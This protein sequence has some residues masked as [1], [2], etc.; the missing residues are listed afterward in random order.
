MTA[1]SKNH[2]TQ[3]S[4][5]ALPIKRYAAACG[6]EAV[7][8]QAEVILD[9][10]PDPELPPPSEPVAASSEAFHV[11]TFEKAIGILRSVETKPASM[12]SWAEPDESLREDRRGELPEFFIEAFPSRTGCCVRPA[13]LRSGSSHFDLS[14]TPHLEP[15]LIWQERRQKPNW[16]LAPVVQIDVPTKSQMGRTW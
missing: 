10:G 3:Q 4:A 16:I 1:N 7:R 14:G 9:R 6:V 12:H 15:K 5:A 2:P 11:V 13:A 8:K